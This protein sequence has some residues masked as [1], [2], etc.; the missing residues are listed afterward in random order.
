MSCAQDPEQSR[1]ADWQSLIDHESFLSFGVALT[2]LTLGVVGT[3][4]SDD[5]L[6]CFIVGNSFTW[7]DWFRVQTEDHKV[8]DVIDQLLNVSVKFGPPKTNPSSRPF[9]PWTH[10]R[11]LGFYRAH[12]DTHQSAIFLYIGAIMP[13]AEFGNYWGITPWRLVLLGICVILFRRLPWVL[14]LVCFPRLKPFLT[15]LFSPSGSP[16]CLPGRRLHSL[17]TL[18]PLVSAQ[19][20]TPRSPWSSFLTTAAVTVSERKLSYRVCS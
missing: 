2:F 16:Q 20:I 7:D 13:W 19:S 17:A 4:G 9:A 5:I 12:A 8:Q 3:I 15:T 11:T 18:V 14:L 6:C 10:S 1:V